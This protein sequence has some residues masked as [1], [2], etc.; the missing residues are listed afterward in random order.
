[1]LECRDKE[2]IDGSDDPVQHNNDCM[3]GAVQYAFT[4][5]YRKP[6][7]QV[8]SPHMFRF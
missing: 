4:D 1:M 2:V 5:S 3:L 7:Q 6:L 8:F